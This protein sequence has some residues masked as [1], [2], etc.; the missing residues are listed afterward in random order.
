VLSSFTTDEMLRMLKVYALPLQ[1]YIQNKHILPATPRLIVTYSRPMTQGI[2]HALSI[3]NSVVVA[4]LVHWSQTGPLS[5]SFSL[6]FLNLM[7]GV[8]RVVDHPLPEVN[9]DPPLITSSSDHTGCCQNTHDV[10]VY[11]CPRHIAI[12]SVINQESAF[13]HVYQLPPSILQPGRAPDSAMYASEFTSTEQTDHLGPLVTQYYFSLP[14]SHDY[15]ISGGLHHPWKFYLTS[16]AH[17]GSEG[18]I[19]SHICLYNICLSLPHSD[20]ISYPS[21]PIDIIPTILPGNDGTSAPVV[22]IGITGR[23]A[24]WLERHW[25]REEV[26]LMR[27]SHTAAGAMAGV[28]VPP[29]PALPFTPAACHS[30]AFDE[31][32]GRLCVGLETGELYVLDY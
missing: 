30:L 10:G 13:V 28:L 24:V 15:R 11:I 7:T 14:V 6:L 23:R 3:Y 12:T 19:R 18:S 21:A 26:R 29:H 31:V 22:C 1:E 17:P 9:S 25:E 8:T 2:I 32:T 5:P 20:D 4:T 16:F 27:L